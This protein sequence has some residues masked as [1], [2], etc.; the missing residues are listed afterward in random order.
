MA[1]TADSPRAPRRPAG[2]LRE[3][4]R[5]VRQAWQGPQAE[6]AGAAGSASPAAPGA[7][8]RA[9]PSMATR[10]RLESLEP[11]VLLSA[12]PVL[13]LAQAAGAVQVTL[14]AQ[15]DQ[16]QVLQVGLAADGAPRIALDVNGQRWQLGDA[17]QGVQSLQ[18]DAGAGN[19]VLRVDAPALELRID[20]GLGDDVLHGPQADSTWTLTGAGAGELGATRFQGMERLVGA[21]DNQDT[22][23]LRDGG[24][25]AGGV[26]GND[27]GYDTLRIETSGSPDLVY[28]ATG[29]QSGRVLFGG[30][31]IG[32][33][34]LE[35][36][37]V[38]AG[39]SGDVT[40]S[41]T[42]GD[43]DAT[44]TYDAL[45]HQLAVVS[46][47]PAGSWGSF[48]TFLFRAPTGRTLTLNTGF[49]DDVL[50]LGDLRGLADVGGFQLT[51]N[52][53]T[54]L[55][56]RGD[57]GV[58]GGLRLQS[59]GTLAIADGTR[60]RV[61]GDLELV[62][63]AQYDALTYQAYSSL[64]RHIDAA[65]A[66]RVGDG[67][68]VDA[69]SITLNSIATNQRLLD[70]MLDN[71]A[72]AAMGEQQRS[73]LLLPALPQDAIV[74]FV[75][76]GGADRIVRSDTHGNWAA[77]GFV[78]GQTIEVWGSG[79]NDGYYRVASV[80][81]STLT[82]DASAHL[83]NEAAA[84]DAEIR[85]VNFMAS[86][87]V[88]DFH[89]NDI[90]SSDTVVRR[91]G[92]WLAEGFKK[93]QVVR[94]TG[95]ADANGDGVGDN[96]GEFLISDVSASTL[97]FFYPTGIV[98][99]AAVSGATAASALG[100]PGATPVALGDP[101]V[102]VNGTV[103]LAFAP[104][105]G[106]TGTITRSDAGGDWRRQGFAVGQLVTVQGSARNDAAYLVTAVSATTL[107]VQGG[108][109]LLAENAQAAS[110]QAGGSVQA[111]D[112]ESG[113]GWSD[114]FSAP[115]D[116][117]GSSISL[118]SGTWS[119][120]YRA[121]RLLS[122]SGAGAPDGVY[123][124]VSV[125]GNTLTV[126]GAPGDGHAEE[127]AFAVADAPA[128]Q[129]AGD[130]ITRSSGRWADDGFA[131]GQELQ[132]SGAEAGF[133]AN[134][135]TF[136]ITAVQGAM[137]T[138]EAPGFAGFTA[139]QTDAAEVSYVAAQ[140]LP[141]LRF[142]A[143]TQTIV[144]D[145]GSWADDGFVAGRKIGVSGTAT[146][147]AL[148]VVQQVSA[149][150]KTL[151]IDVA[152]SGGARLGD[153]LVRTDSVRGILQQQPVDPAHPNNPL[154]AGFVA[155]SLIGSLPNTLLFAPLQSFPSKIA[156]VFYGTATS[157][158][159]VGAN[160]WLRASGDI[161]LSSNGDANTTVETLASPL[162]AN[163]IH[164][165]ARATVHIGEGATLDAGGALSATATVNHQVNALTD[166]S[167]KTARKLHSQVG[168]RLGLSYVEAYSN[169]EVAVDRGALLAGDTVEIAAG[170]DGNEFLADA[171]GKSKAAK[172][173]RGVRQAGT[174]ATF[175]M[176]GV[177]M[178]DI[179]TQADVV[180]NG[181]VL[182][183]GGDQDLDGDGEADA[184][185]RLRASAE[186]KENDTTALAQLKRP[187]PGPLML[188]GAAAIARG[189]NSATVH[190][191][192]EA[193]LRS[194]GSLAVNTTATDNAQTFAVSSIK[195]RAGGVRFAG[196]L[197]DADYRNQAT[198]R[199]EGGAR[200]D[201]AGATD[202][203]AEAVFPSQIRL[204]YLQNLVDAVQLSAPQLSG[205]DN[206]DAA[207]NSTNPLAGVEQQM[208]GAGRG[209]EAL[210]LWGVESASGVFQ[211]VTD[212][213]PLAKY[214][215]LVRNFMATTYVEASTKNFDGSL[216]LLG[217]T[218]QRNASVM[219][220]QALASVGA[221]ALINQDPTLPADPGRTVSLTADSRIDA[222][223]T[224]GL[225]KPWQPFKSQ[226]TGGQVG[227]GLTEL[228]A[229]YEGAAEA[230]IEDGARVHADGDVQVLATNHNRTVG[231]TLSGAKS[232]IGASDSLAG[233]QASHRTRAWIEDGATV[234]S[235]GALRV[236]AALD[237][238][239]LQYA[240]A[241]QGIG[242]KAGGA[243]L[244]FGGVQL[245]TTVD[246][247]TEAFI[248]NALAAPAG[249]AGPGQ[250][251]AT[252]I[253]VTA[254]AEERTLGVARS[255]SKAQV[256][257][258]AASLLTH[259]LSST[260]RAAATD[261]V[262]ATGALTVLASGDAASAALAYQTAGGR[263]SVAGVG[264]AL[265]RHGGTRVVDALVGGEVSADSVS[266]RA[267]WAG[268]VYSASVG[269]A[270]GLLS[271][272][273][274]ATDLGGS[275]RVLA[276]VAED[277]RLNVRGDLSVHAQ[278]A[279]ERIAITGS[280]SGGRG[281]ATAGASVDH[282]DFATTVVAE[283]GDGARL[284]VAGDLAV[285]AASNNHL[286]SVGATLARGTLGSL[287]GSA[288]T[289]ALD[290][291]VEAVVR[292]GADV[293][294]DGDA[295]LEALDE[296]PVVLVAGSAAFGRQ[297]GFG[298]SAAGLSL[299]RSVRAGIA[300][301]ARF[302]ADG[303]DAAGGGL[304]S[305][306]G[307]PVYG[308]RIRALA[309]D[310][311]V[312]TAA[313]GANSQLL[314]LAASVTDLSLD[315][316]V[317]AFIGDAARV[318]LR[319]P[320]GAAADQAVELD[321]R[322][323]LR[324][325]AIAGGLAFGGRLAVG[326]SADVARLAMHV[327]AAIGAGAQVAA[328]DDV[329]V[330]A[331]DAVELLS[332]TATG[333]LS[334]G[335]PGVAVDGSVATLA[336]QRDT[337]AQVGAGTRLSAGDD[338]AVQAEGALNLRMVEAGV[339]GGGT[340]GFG[341]SVGLFEHDNAV[342]AEVGDAAS[343]L[344]GGDLRVDA[345]NQTRL[346]AVAGTLAL[347]GQLAG[348]GLS[349]ATVLQHEDVEARVGQDGA[350]LAAGRGTAETV[351]TARAD[352]A[353]REAGFHGVSITATSA[354]DV[355][356]VAAG[357]ALAGQV[358]VAGSGAALLLTQSA[359]AT[360]GDRTRVEAT[361]DG[362]GA[363]GINVFAD[364]RSTVT[365]L[366]GAVGV[367]GAAGLGAGVGLVQL[368]KRTEARLGG[369][370]LAEGHVRVQALSS[371]SLVGAGGGAGVG[372]T[373]GVAGGV[374]LARLDLGTLAALGAGAS[375]SADGSVVVAADDQ[376]TVDLVGGSLSGS[377]LASLGGGA[378]LATVAKTVDAV[379]GDG[380]R[381]DARGLLALDV[382]AGQFG[383]PST[384]PWPPATCRWPLPQ[385]WPN[386]AS[387]TTRRCTASAAWAR[388]PWPASA[389]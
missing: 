143:A 328:R 223:H 75:D 268:T 70:L 1:H 92:D 107:T 380:A 361:G 152:A 179:H 321:A 263:T 108:S 86:G 198:L 273:G 357:G 389:A 249:V 299:R 145:V 118:A 267:L 194:A 350:L 184:A 16:V 242:Q 50:R 137:L 203:H 113:S 280:R 3:L 323:E 359:R 259:E 205:T 121:G 36:V 14:G 199:V 169:S 331:A 218:G 265:S 287:S 13:A 297:L 266:V 341:G 129:F 48:E 87:T 313:A 302:D 371:E 111:G 246:N 88:L 367:G 21:V 235:G 269:S 364:H 188:A 261:S 132:V 29:A 272:T 347:G 153:E 236:D 337:L 45:T 219:H 237:Q 330:H 122:V 57:A 144:R 46:N 250:V 351:A 217:F 228:D 227:L 140:G 182:A 358:G 201:A 93:Y 25:L 291:T 131:V 116:F 360:V 378:A 353:V 162:G 83:S 19:D 114:D 128:L 148:Y 154:T 343:L 320:A 336:L 346:L 322:H 142:D 208:A 245:T 65:A 187:A 348:L 66:I 327:G 304:R 31:A 315:S 163:Y 175:G 329:R 40:I 190:L 231:L 71:I 314:T 2:R 18:L 239:T 325:L 285:L 319:D 164:S 32:F 91:S 202:L 53:T 133:G 345:D 73:G 214:K 232:V 383:R 100:D 139:E 180:V 213:M 384:P 372:Q 212:L 42:P 22:F 61:G 289:L 277:A 238:F 171:G 160:A 370:S 123:R 293:Q 230:W 363:E 355:L 103:P 4:A 229:R 168:P 115:S 366:G 303:H 300:D 110:V 26:D 386:T 102:R 183:R 67:A 127:A 74:Q 62:A 195:G 130:T 241:D 135:G 216:Q 373:L 120:A 334:Y 279:T 257:A 56:L 196:A 177:A 157:D 33:D 278:Q 76:D 81:P 6:A 146:N 191:G 95:T 207:N 125:T 311:P 222:L 101:E 288:V 155:E 296:T 165:T 306:D 159:A 271:A 365:A 43:N 376:T 173:V 167:P 170:N 283:V 44:L 224:A 211:A 309:V 105:G 24:S 20:G 98:E 200:L 340:A 11:R 247:L 298:A 151:A 124:I 270:A 240:A 96:D 335:G 312:L 197:V 172:F 149:D 8:C 374:A 55:T 119:G 295:L 138:V 209:L 15:D 23:V 68:Q 281:Q 174:D 308:L 294:V 338:I 282:G 352:Q 192:A 339:A 290:S 47:L 117:S 147:D 388:R 215:H 54:S 221:G 333:A 63:N 310:T 379:V 193:V 349:A 89:H 344:A 253:T 150:G 318:N 104:S 210:T 189:D 79:A 106:N 38:L 286:V 158:I 161:T 9:A 85:A 17:A 34:G 332:V 78:A 256:A 220:N 166:T 385:A 178:S 72:I 243:L 204:D 275:V 342:R 82:L 244:A 292:A 59:G 324:P 375:V 141:L 369:D 58:D 264:G 51:V 7:R 112:P 176:S 225:G 126:D 27:G 99:Q 233:Y 254:S 252:A 226:S 80:L 307:Q 276:G 49:G 260:I 181:T 94:F 37:S 77:D 354:H 109:P 274:S 387:T 35:P 41:L 84:T 185:L 10:F 30:Q 255:A 97:T 251:Q 28:E 356:A 136:V 301:N 156:S 52:S 60:L 284:D 64:Q 39:A 5:R 12:D 382:L 262:L 368:D 377:G 362:T 134:N 90:L 317:D 326:A 206:G 305:A 69:A 316:T 186:N 248:G 234:D 381:V 258:A